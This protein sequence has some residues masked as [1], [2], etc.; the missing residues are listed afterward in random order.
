[1]A[2]TSEIEPL[3]I[4]ASLHDAP[5]T[6]VT[7]VLDQ[8]HAPCT[9]ALIWEEWA[10]IS[11]RF[12]NLRHFISVRSYELAPTDLELRGNIINCMLGLLAI[13]EQTQLSDLFEAM[14]T[15]QADV[16][17]YVDEPLPLEFFPELGAVA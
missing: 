8:L 1:M 16:K 5:E 13:E 4:P 10:T 7:S 14:L 6:I 3:R 2:S 12:P 17:L 11:Q 9:P 15:D